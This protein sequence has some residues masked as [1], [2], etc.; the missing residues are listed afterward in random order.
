M[1]LPPIFLYASWEEFRFFYVV[2]VIDDCGDTSL[3]EWLK[4]GDDI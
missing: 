3:L 4:S 1:E 2:G